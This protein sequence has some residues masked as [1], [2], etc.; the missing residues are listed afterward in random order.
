[1][2]ETGAEHASDEAGRGEACPVDHNP[3]QVAPSNRQPTIN[4]AARGGVAG[5]KFL[6]AEVDT[7]RST[8]LDIELA[9]RSIVDDDHL[10]VIA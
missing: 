10:V 5:R 4:R 7:R 6:D 1:M 9:R 3:A 2:E 8:L